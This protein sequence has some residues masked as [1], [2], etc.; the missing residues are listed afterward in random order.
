MP[1]ITL[2]YVLDSI[3]KRI[4]TLEKNIEKYHD[5]FIRFEEGKLTQALQDIEKNK[6][7]IRQIKDYLL[8]S[9]EKEDN[10]I[11]RRKDWVWGALEK[12]V[13][14]ALGISFTIIGLVLSKLGILNLK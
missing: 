10:M 4:D 3:N 2:Q 13:F 5:S 8:N 12:I 6:G 14:I 9:T 1:E 11:Q 7:D